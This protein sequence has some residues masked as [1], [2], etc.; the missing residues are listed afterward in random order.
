MQNG[1]CSE[2]K[3]FCGMVLVLSFSTVMGK[4]GAFWLE[5]CKCLHVKKQANSVF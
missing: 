4:M 5:L 3:E 1:N 2:A